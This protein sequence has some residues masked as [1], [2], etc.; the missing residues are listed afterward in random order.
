MKDT[1][2]PGGSRSKKR[3]EEGERESDKEQR[4]VSF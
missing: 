1:D 4:E 3:T 2:A